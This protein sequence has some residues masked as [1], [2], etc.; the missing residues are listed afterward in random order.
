[1]ERVWLFPGGPVLAEGGLHQVKRDEGHLQPP[2]SRHT[3]TIVH[4]H[5]SKPHYSETVLPR[6]H[7]KSHT[8]MIEPWNGLLLLGADQIQP[9]GLFTKTG[10]LI[11]RN[12]IFRLF[13]PVSGSRG[14][15]PRPGGPR[16][17]CAPPRRSPRPAPPPRPAR[18]RWSP[19]PPPRRPWAARPPR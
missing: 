8:Q 11:M 1:M 3:S 10:D 2:V 17:G 16:P 13:R 12:S 4:Q 9:I 14:W 18:R 19:G 5:T 7:Q 15:P 6:S